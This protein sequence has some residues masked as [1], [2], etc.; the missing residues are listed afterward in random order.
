M[1][2][3][4]NIP[5]R[6]LLKTPLQSIKFSVVGRDLFFFHKNTPG[7]PEGA[8]S[9]SDYAQAFENTSMPPTRSFGFNLNI[10]F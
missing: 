9:R 10:K 5:K 4:W 6:W 2:L 1:S 3:G 8:N 7:N